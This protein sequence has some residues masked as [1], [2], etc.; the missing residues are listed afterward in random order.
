MPNRYYRNY[1][2]RLQG[3]LDCVEPRGDLLCG[4][5]KAALARLVPVVRFV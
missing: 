4:V 3:Y 2:G 1:L 5:E